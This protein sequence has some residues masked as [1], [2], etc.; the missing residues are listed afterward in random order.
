MHKILIVSALSQELNT[1]KAQIKNL[2]IKN[3]KISFFTTWMGNY[4]TILNLTRFLEKND[5][6]FLVNI[7]ICWY[8]NEKVYFFQV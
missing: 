1:I 6:D 2:K 5:F 3:L 8:K 4:N 7:W